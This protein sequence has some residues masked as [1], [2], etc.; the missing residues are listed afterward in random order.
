MYNMYLGLGLGKQSELCLYPSS[1]LEDNL[2]AVTYSYRVDGQVRNFCNKNFS[3]WFMT[4]D[5]MT[6]KLHRYGVIPSLI[7]PSVL[8]PEEDVT[9]LCYKLLQM[10]VSPPTHS[11]EKTLVAKVRPSRRQSF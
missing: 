4:E 1:Q 6:C 11:I 3:D 7:W 8:D 2:T 10:A 5:E 9:E